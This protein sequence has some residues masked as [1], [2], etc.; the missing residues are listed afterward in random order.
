MR[1]RR[2]GA[3]ILRMSTSGRARQLDAAGRSLAR[4]GEH[5]AAY[6]RRQHTDESGSRTG[7]K[8]ERATAH[9]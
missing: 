1:S 2:A 7:G 3:A 6:L 9:N 4:P 5:Q 8:A